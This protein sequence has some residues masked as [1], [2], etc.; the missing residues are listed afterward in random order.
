MDPSTDSHSPQETGPTGVPQSRNPPIG[1]PTRPRVM[2]VM[3]PIICHLVSWRT[4][5]PTHDTSWRTVPTHDEARSTEC[6][7]TALASALVGPR[8]HQGFGPQQ[9]N[10]IAWRYSL[11]AFAIMQPWGLASLFLRGLG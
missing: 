4:V 7:G 9:L 10:W 2:I 3:H 1:V 8:Y 5:T 6:H 11:F